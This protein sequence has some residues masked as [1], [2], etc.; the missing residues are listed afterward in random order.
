MAF[1]IVSGVISFSN[2]KVIERDSWQVF[3][4]HEVI[5]ALDD[6]LS[7]LKDAETGQRGYLL[8]GDERYLE[9][10]NQA[11]S[12]LDSSLDEIKTLSQQTGSGE[13][14]LVEV[15]S[16]ID[17]KMAELEETI[18]LRR[19][20]GFEAARR[21]VLSD[22]GRAEMDTL[23]G[24]VARIKHDEEAIRA[25]RLVEMDAATR[26]ALT[27]GVLSA[28]LGLLLSCLVAVLAQRALRVRREQEWI[29]A[30]RVGL[31]TAISGDPDVPQLAE[32]VLGYLCEYVQAHVGVFYAEADG[33]YQR[34]GSYA[35]GTDSQAPVRFVPGEGLLGQA[36]RDKRSYL[37]TDIPPKYVKVSSSLGKSEP[38]QLLIAPTLADG[39]VRAVFELGFIHPL[40]PLAHAFV[41]QSLESIGIA[42]RSAVERKRVQDLLEETQRQGEELQAQSEELRV[43]NEELAEQ[44]RALKESQARLEQQQAELEQTNAQ[45]EEQT[46][47]LEAQRDNL[48]DIRQE[49]EAKAKDLERTS[50]FKSDFLANM[51]HELRTPLNSSLILAKLLADNR[52]GNLSDEQ[53]K[54]A[55]T[56]YAAG[57][58]LLTLISDILDLSKIE[59]GHMEVHPEELDIRDLVERTTRTFMPL[60]QDKGLEFV[61]CAHPGTPTAILTDAGRFEQVL[62]NLI[63]N[64]IKFTEAGS[65]ALEILPVGT[66]KIAFAV[67]DT[68]IGIAENQR[69]MVFEAFRQADGTT[70]R[71]Y[72]GTGLGLSI[73]RELSQLLGGEISLASEVGKG[74]TFTIT[75]PVQFGAKI[76]VPPAVDPLPEPVVRPASPTPSESPRPSGRLLL[77][78]ED[79]VRFAKIL[80]DLAAEHRFECLIANTASEGLR[81]AFE[82]LPSAVLLD[83]GLPDNSGL[84]VL[85]RLKHDDR[86][87]HIPVHVVS[88]RDLNR[89]AITLGAAGFALKPVNRKDLERAFDDLE[90]ILTQQLKRVLIVEDDPVQL[91]SLHLLLGTRSIETVGAGSAAEC[92]SLLANKTFD[93]MVL[94]LSLPDASGFTLL[95]T[96]SREETYAFPPVIVYT[97]RDLSPDEEQ[98]LRHYSKSIIVKG[99]KSPERLLD[100]VTLFLHQVVAELPVE[101]RRLIEKAKH[102]DAD[103]EGRRVLV[104]EDDIRNVFAL[105]SIL[106]PRGAHVAIARNG[107]EAIEMLEREESDIDLV[108]MDV[109]MPEMDGLTAMREIRKR[110]EWRKLPIIA[111]TAK[112]MKNDQEECL[113]AGAN[114]Y[115]AKPLDV[116]KLLSLVRVWMPRD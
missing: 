77:V 86:T 51:S 99:A 74:S 60:A 57:N 34:V 107:R 27:S 103:L 5:T 112:A 3:R 47:E 41:E 110:S 83:I 63:S 42:V 44:T 15:R 101:K 97:G 78:V 55:E 38:R 18:R 62:K 17:A 21:L 12:E 61:A 9:P 31:A 36:V 109:M 32:R 79:D 106:E 39:R 71:K 102:R 40:S 11:R 29:H 59:A 56:I 95:D 108:L 104:A 82:Y 91:E 54:Y 2:V 111:L 65:V 94:D 80:A 22:R 89:A 49:L 115:I 10:F 114:D 75:L 52:E 84:S 73:S 92:L 1:F 43:S 81:M 6:L 58:D 16:H 48:S 85:D 113:A 98:R 19:T 53:I 30:G 76:A 46:Q 96:L 88:G 28:I 72:G 13:T 35:L 66:E 33:A 93:C 69:E 70:K 26:S 116:D 24:L 64:A 45:L 4:T 23:R 8:T 37:V 90:R 68:G 105:T 14:R 7:T 25:Q 20:Q 67:I 87:R 100:E 50:R